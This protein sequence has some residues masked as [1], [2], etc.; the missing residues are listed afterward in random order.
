MLVCILYFPICRL[1]E[2][3]SLTGID[4][5]EVNLSYSSIE[6]LFNSATGTM[7]RFNTLSS[8]IKENL[9]NSGDE[10]VLDRL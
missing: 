3:V 1:S 2:F 9:L 8:E 6:A 7:L 5:R 10:K 4:V